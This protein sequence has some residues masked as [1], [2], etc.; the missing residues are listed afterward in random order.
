MELYSAGTL[1]VSNRIWAAVSRFDRGFKGGSVSST[2]CYQTASRPSALEFFFFWL[3]IK[4]VDML[5][6]L[7]KEKILISSSMRLRTV[8]VPLHLKSST[9]QCTHIA[10]SFPYHP[11]L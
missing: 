3:V 10:I 1:K 7:V 11:N 2:G 8:F 5:A 9:L 4:S 6:G